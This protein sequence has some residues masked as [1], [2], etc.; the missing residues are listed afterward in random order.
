MT[1][2]IIIVLTGAAIATIAVVIILQKTKPGGP[3]FRPLAVGMAILAVSG[4]IA[5]IVDPPKPA[6]SCV[7]PGPSSYRTVW[8]AQ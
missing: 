8:I 1:P 5:W 7:A 4:I 6:P 2:F 3:F